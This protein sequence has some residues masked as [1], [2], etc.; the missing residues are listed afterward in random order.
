MKNLKSTL[1]AGLAVVL[2]SACTSFIEEPNPEQSL[3]SS[4]AFALASDLQTALIGA[5]QSIQN[6]DMAGN[7]TALN[8]N[9]LSDNGTW[10]G[11]FPSYIDMSNRQLTY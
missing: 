5:Y 7:G 8:A 1:L 3:P 9:I 11:S 6:S 10:Q 4:S 2:V